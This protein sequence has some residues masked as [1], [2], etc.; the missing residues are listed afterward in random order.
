MKKIFLILPFLLSA[1]NAWIEVSA[2]YWKPWEKAL[3]ATNKASD[4]FTTDDFTENPVIH[5]DFEWSWGYRLD[6]GYRFSCFWDISASWTHYTSHVHQNRTV[7]QYAFLGMFPIWSLSD[8]IIAGDTIFQSHLQW[9][10]L[11]NLLDVQFDYTWPYRCLDITPY[12]GVRSAWIKQYGNVR[13]Q[14]GIFLIGIIEPGISLEGSDDI[15]MKNNYWG[16]GPRIG[17]SPKWQLGRGF[18]LNGDAAI[19]SLYG[20]FHVLQKETYLDATRFSN[21]KHIHR[22]CWISDFS[23]GLE[24]KTYFKCSALTLKADWEYHIFFHQFVL[25]RD[26][27]HLIPEDKDL[28][29]QGVTFSARLDF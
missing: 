7:D 25:Q 1:E 16:L 4:I 12:F 15:Q 18:S 19:S 26:R 29:T 28:S 6:G 3:V 11:I 17:L 23:A 13:Y 24:W 21:D 2:L 5:P 27:F 14:G 8:D 22:F 20:F 9:K 10:F